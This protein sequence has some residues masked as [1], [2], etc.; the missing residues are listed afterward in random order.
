MGR[1]VRALCQF[2]WK[3][4]REPEKEKRGQRVLPEGASLRHGPCPKQ[5]LPSAF[6]RIS[7]LT[8]SN[9]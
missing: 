4:Q 6:L 9:L 7:T 3:D 8:L 2:S 5:S 1:G